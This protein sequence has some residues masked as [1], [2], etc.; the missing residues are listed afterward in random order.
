M[1]KEQN[2]K[3]LLVLLVILGLVFIACAWWLFG[4]LKPKS[5]IQVVNND[6]Q[7]QKIFTLKEIALDNIE[8]FLGVSG[9]P[10]SIFE[11]LYNDPQYRSLKD[12]NIDIDISDNVGNSHPFSSSTPNSQ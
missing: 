8:K 3:T 5:Q 6:I 2:K 4:I 11:N 7:V 12:L 10:S 1:A 9:R